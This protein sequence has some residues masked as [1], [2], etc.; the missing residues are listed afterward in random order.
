MY[1][2]TCM[3]RRFG[4]RRWFAFVREAGLVASVGLLSVLSACTLLDKTERC[5]TDPCGEDSLVTTQWASLFD[6]TTLNGWRVHGEQGV[7]RVENGEIIGELV[8]KSPYAYLVTERKF[9]DFDLELQL[10]F[11]SEEGNSGVFFRCDFPAWK[12]KDKQKNV[13][14]YEKRVHIVGPQAEFAPPN[15]PHT[16]RLFDAKIGKW[17]SPELTEVQQMMHRF[18]EWN[19]MRITAIGNYVTVYLNGYLMAELVD[20]KFRPDGVIALQLHAGKAMKARFKDIRI[21]ER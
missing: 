1:V 9:K 3:V 13:V 21:R 4:N 19:R 7:W 12:N 8:K 5:E 17:I 14:P 15:H 11:E 6:G 16:G 2:S 10:L 18:Q 20:Y